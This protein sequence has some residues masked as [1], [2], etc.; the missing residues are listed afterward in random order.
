MRLRPG[1]ISR[2]S[3]RGGIGRRPSRH[4]TIAQAV[5]HP[6]PRGLACPSTHR[7]VGVAGI[8]FMDL[9]RIVLTAVGDHGLED[10]QFGAQRRRPAQHHGRVIQVVEQ[11][12][13]EHNL[14]GGELGHG[15]DGRRVAW[16]IVRRAAGQVIRIPGAGGDVFAPRF[17]ACH[18]T[19]AVRKK[20]V[21]SPMPAPS[22]STVRCSTGS[23]RVAKCS[24]R[25]RDADRGGCEK[26]RSSGH[27]VPT[28]CCTQASMSGMVTLGRATARKLSNDGEA[29]RTG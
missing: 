19:L 5:E 1:G 11:P 25:R 27:L 6:A 12:V 2:W 23:A 7:V 8:F 3:S 26:P 9:K 15:V 13:A 10:H 4:T 17:D 16:M 29:V 20:E 21:S 24:S 22:S 18:R 14:M 28:S